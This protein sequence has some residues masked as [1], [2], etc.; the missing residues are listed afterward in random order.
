VRQGDVVGRI[1]GDEL[2]VVAADATAAD[3]VT[4]AARV[5][6]AV[7]AATAGEG[8]DVTIGVAIY[9]DDGATSTELVEVA[10]RAMYQGK[11]RGP[12]SIVVGSPR[13]DRS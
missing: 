6:V 4:L 7:R 1:G 9:P 10:D 5:G 8:V 13:A 2:L 3:A 11:L 12:G